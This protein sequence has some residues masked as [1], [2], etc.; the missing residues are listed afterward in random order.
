MSTLKFTKA[1]AIDEITYRRIPKPRPPR[2]F[3][4]GDAFYASAKQLAAKAGPR[5]SATPAPAKKTR[6]RTPG[7]NAATRAAN[8]TTHAPGSA[9]WWAVYHAHVAATRALA[10]V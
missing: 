8:A 4:P 3:V 10:S 2:D 9:P 7:G 5:A 1:Q 6:T